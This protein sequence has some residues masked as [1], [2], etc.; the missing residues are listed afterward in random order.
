MPPLTNPYHA[1][2]RPHPRLKLQAPL[3]L[4]GRPRAGPREW[5]HALHGP[6]PLWPPDRDPGVL[7]LLQPQGEI[8]SLTWSKWTPRAPATLGPRLRFRSA[9]SFPSVS[10][11]EGVEHGMSRGL[12]PWVR[13]AQG[14]LTSRG[15]AANVGTAQGRC[16]S[17]AWRCACWDG[18][19]GGM[20][21]LSLGLRPAW[22]G[23]M[24]GSWARASE[25]K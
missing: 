24:E 25:C 23:R 11:G 7:P 5:R 6:Q 2:R 17:R 12:A 16:R 21:L 4:P 22:Q 18:C 10:K 15:C 1:Q 14:A 13:P 8:Q 19:W 20:L 9:S 3:P